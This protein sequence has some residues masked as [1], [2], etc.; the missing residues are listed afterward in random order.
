[1]YP[2]SRFLDF[3]KRHN[4]FN[5]DDT[6]LLAVSGGRDSVFMA[7]LFKKAGINFAIAHCNFQLRNSESD[8]DEQFVRDLAVML[9]VPLHV[10]HFDTPGDAASKGISIQ[11]VARELRYEW[12]SQLCI[13]HNYSAVAVAHHQSDNTETLLLNL[14]RGTGIAGLH[15]IRPKRDHIIR[16]L[17]FLNREEIDHIVNQSDMPYREDSSNSSAKYARNK[18]RLK[19]V[20]QLRQINPSLDETFC[21][22]SERLWE[23]EQFLKRSVK[24]LKND[25]FNPQPNGEIHITVSALKTL[26]PRKL[27]LFELFRDFNFQEN[28]LD[29]LSKSWDHQTGKQFLSS[30]HILLLDREKLI[31]RT[32]TSDIADEWFIDK[33]CDTLRTSFF[34]LHTVLHDAQDVNIIA[35]NSRAWLDEE[36]LVYP[37]TLRRWKHGDVFIPFGMRGKKKVSDFLISRKVALLHKNEVMVIENGNGHLLWV[38]GY[39]SDDRYKI[40]AQTKK[41]RIFECLLP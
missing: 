20:P 39:R 14:T 24:A 3:A 37:L 7:K 4:L 10:T 33:D 38:V 28:V 36:L 12:F 41:V 9:E 5:M 2:V 6:V 13:Q 11:M 16:P 31:L 30:S 19:V 32:R 15:G 29:D 21:N 22:N 34:T 25:L 40:T 8:G 27:L 18:I 35:E 1:M 23:L 26:Y 17:L